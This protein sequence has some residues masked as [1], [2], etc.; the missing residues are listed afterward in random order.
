MPQD[1]RNTAAKHG[2][3]PAAAGAYVSSDDLGAGPAYFDHDDL[4]LGLRIGQVGGF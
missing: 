3:P 4:G 1:R 2:T